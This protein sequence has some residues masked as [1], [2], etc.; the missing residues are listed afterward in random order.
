MKV[1][2]LGTGLMGTALAEAL[3]KSGHEVI[4]YNRTIS[5][6]VPLLAMGATLAQTPAEAISTADVSII[7]LP[8]AGSVRE[9][10]LREEVRSVLQGKRLLNASTTKPDDI[11]EMAKLVAE[12]GGK[13]AEVSIMIG[14]DEL[15]DSKGQFILGCDSSDESFFSDLLKSTAKRI[16]RA[17]DVGDASKAEVPI[18]ITSVFGVVTAAYA[19]AAA[20]KLNVPKEISQHYIPM[21]APH[22]EYLLPNLLSRNYD[23]CM[24]SIDNF[25]VV[26]EN[27]ISAAISAGLPTTILESIDRLFTL[28]AVHG[29]GK[30]DGTA[31]NE[32]LLNP[33][34]FNA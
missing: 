27:A 29:F 32:I 4:V 15:R 18:L 21:S 24:A 2:I 26:S 10:L 13:L 12:E 19:A 1:S 22:S 5:R 23:S 9:L 33:K 8:D 34:N 11:I 30:K 28:A 6:T 31:I 20:I 3:L 25:S 17:G 7:V 16:D 14:A